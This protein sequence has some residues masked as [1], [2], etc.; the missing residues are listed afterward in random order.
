MSVQEVNQENLKVAD[1]GLWTETTPPVVV[2]MS[3]RAK[4]HM[5][6]PTDVCGAIF[7]C[8][9]LHWMDT[10]PSDYIIANLGNDWRPRRIVIGELILAA[11]S[12]H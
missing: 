11:E 3:K 9:A 12:L 2:P 5:E 1:I 4:A 10:V 7:L 8:D 6:L